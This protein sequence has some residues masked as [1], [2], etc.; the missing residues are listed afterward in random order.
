M[1]FHKNSKTYPHANGYF[2]CEKCKTKVDSIDEHGI[3]LECRIDKK[4]NNKLN[5][6]IDDKSYS[7]DEII[8]ILKKY[9]E[10]EDK[11]YQTCDICGDK[12][13]ENNRYNM[14]YYDLDEKPL[15]PRAYAIGYESTPYIKGIKILSTCGTGKDV[16]MCD[17]CVASLIH[18]LKK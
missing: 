13:L 1:S 6:V 5:F 7:T 17:T 11:K 10:E 12:Y 3:C 9:K 4:R 15:E 14:C 18:M 8:E 16:K 2:I